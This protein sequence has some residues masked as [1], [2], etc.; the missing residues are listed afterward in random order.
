MCTTGK[1]AF[2]KNVGRAG[3]SEGTADLWLAGGQVEAGG[4]KG[5]GSVVHMPGSTQPGG[6][7][8]LG[9]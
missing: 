2:G 9:G 5:R 4:G 7:E 1:E 8:V 6:T 3:G